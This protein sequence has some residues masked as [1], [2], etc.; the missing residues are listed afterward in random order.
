MKCLRCGGE[1][2]VGSWPFCKGDPS[3]HATAR[4]RWA[5]GIPTIV[6]RNAE[7]KVWYPVG[8]AAMP[9]SG[10]E[11]V[12]L[13][14]TRERDRFEREIGSQ[15]T[16]KFRENVYG[17]QKAWERTIAEQMEGIKSLR[18]MSPGGRLFYDQIQKD[19]EKTRK[20]FDARA[21]GEAGFHIVGN[22]YYGNPK[23][24]G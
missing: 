7:G 4:S 20:E 15:E 11:K 22:H 17:Q 21:K 5:E 12:E 24:D 8:D 3:D 16:A 6:Y 2:V 13:R 19:I 23:E 10:Y 1:L 14:N 18:E 9:P